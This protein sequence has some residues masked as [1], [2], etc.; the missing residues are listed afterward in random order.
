MEAHLKAPVEKLSWALAFLVRF[1]DIWL[2]LISAI[3]RTRAINS[4]CSSVYNKLI[5]FT[6]LIFYNFYS[7]LNFFSPSTSPSAIAFSISSLL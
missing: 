4:F 7:F 3:S 6:F 1:L 2:D 5:F